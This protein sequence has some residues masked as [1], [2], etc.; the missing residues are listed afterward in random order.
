[1]GDRQDHPGAVLACYLSRV[2]EVPPDVLTSQAKLS[3]VNR[4]AFLSLSALTVA[5][6]RLVSE[7]TASIGQGD[8]SPLTRVQTTQRT[9]LVIA[10]LR[11]HAER[12]K[13]RGWMDN[14]G[15]E[16]LR[17]NA[18]GILAKT[19]DQDTAELVATVLENDANTRRLYSNC[20]HRMGG[21]VALDHRGQTRIR[22]YPADLEAFPRIPV[23]QR[24]AQPRD[25]G[26]RWCS[27]AMLKDL[28]PLL[29]PS[30]P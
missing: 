20:R 10:S 9:D 7:M 21:R 27:A 29:G 13:L 14:G 22:T 11:G 30:Q 25:A 16:I 6:G 19:P 1:L 5:H 12:R 2:L 15:S 3:R 8:Y 17:V 26:T 24:G 4:R 23:R 18:A 28:S